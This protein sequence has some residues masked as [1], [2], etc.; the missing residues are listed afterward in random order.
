MIIGLTG[1]AQSGK[2]TAYHFL[3]EGLDVEV[4]RI[5]FAK[6]LKES[7]AAAIGANGPDPV[8]LMDELKLTGKI[9]VEVNG[10]GWTISGR[11]YLQRY[12]TEAH[13]VLF[14]ADFWIDRALPSNTSHSGRLLV[15]TDVRFPNEASRI[16]HLG[17]QVWRIDRD[18]AA[19]VES[20]ASEEGLPSELIDLVISN[21]GTKDEFRELLVRNAQAMLVAA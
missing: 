16:I 10:Y 11:E 21:N 20:H 8:A 12:G 15:V 4:K 2:D 6:A 1:K 13:R 5:S 3:R 7:A 19:E 17:G 14:G 9:R 18:S